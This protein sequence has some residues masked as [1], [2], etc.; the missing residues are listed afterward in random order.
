VVKLNLGDLFPV[1]SPI[2][3]SYK[4]YNPAYFEEVLLDYKKDK[5]TSRVAQ[6]YRE[7]FLVDSKSI[8][9]VL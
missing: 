5:N 4:V 9:Q 2:S 6:N 8:Y 7:R 3:H 1:N